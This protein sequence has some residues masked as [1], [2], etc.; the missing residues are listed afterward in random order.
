MTDKMNAGKTPDKQKEV[1]ARGRR[2]KKRA[3]KRTKAKTLPEVAPEEETPKVGERE[4]LVNATGNEA[5]VAVVED[6]AVVEFYTERPSSQKIAGSVFL[7]KVV[8]VLPGMQAAFVDIGE[9]KN[10][11][12][13]VKDALT[14]PNLDD[15]DGPPV[16]RK[17]KKKGITD[18]VRPGEQIVVQ[19]IKEAIGT[20]GARVTRHVTFPGR[21]L[22]LMPTVDYVGVSRRITTEDERRR[23]RKIARGIKPANVGLIIR[24]VA[25]NKTEEEIQND[26]DFLLKVW[27]NVQ[28]K[29][30]SA[31]APSVIHRDSELVFRVVRDELNE[32]TARMIVDDVS[33]YGKVLDLLDAVSPGMKDRVIYYRDKETPLFDTY[34]VESA[35]EKALG[36]QVWLRSGGYLVIDHTEALTVIDVNTGRYVGGKNLADTVFKT[37]MEACEEI[38]RQLRLRDVGGIIIVDFIDM[39]T[40]S[41]RA[42]LLQEFEEKLKSDH[43]KTVVVGLTGLGLVELTR[44]KVRGSIGDIM[45]RPC[46]YCLGKGTV[47]SEETVAGKV[48][49]EIR[50]ILKN[51][52]S[53]AI[54]VEV[55]PGVASYLIGPGGVNLRALEKE[56]GKNIF[57]RGCDASHHEGMTVKAVG[58]KEDIAEKAVPVQP[59]Q[60]LEVVVD[61]AHAQHPVDGI[62]RVEGYVLRVENGSQYVGEHVLVEITSCSKTYAKAKVVGEAS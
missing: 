53:E 54:L 26:L 38:V 29:A 7:G 36:R 24:T 17:R 45:T 43:T 48:R 49:R 8:N 18:L 60:K 33:V 40:P 37:N 27:S 5:R 30:R 11:F 44:K 57:I 55:H 39:E 3:K 25:E 32:S 46:P 12:L 22:V 42:R 6:G 41:H 47:L 56:T 20:K 16:P 23:L 31:K 52:S 28:K 51:S 2:F 58:T 15:L 21:Y 50:R 4:I 62:A 35:V 34:G 14:P 13:Y 61:E 19:V 9:E 10:A 1:R 59:G